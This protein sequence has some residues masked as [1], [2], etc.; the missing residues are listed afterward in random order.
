MLSSAAELKLFYH[1]SEKM[2][3][4]EFQTF[5]ALIDYVVAL[6]LTFKPEA[7]I[8]RSFL[9]FKDLR[10]GF[11]KEL[12]RSE[13]GKLWKELI[14][15]HPDFPSAGDLKRNMSISNIYI[16]M[17]DIHG[18]TRFC[19][20]SKG[21]L[22]R[23]RKLDD[24][25]HEGIRK[26][27]RGNHALANR[28]R[29]DEIVVVASSATDC[30]KTT[31]EIISTFSKHAVVKDRAVGTTR[32]DYSI[33]LPD[34]KVTAGI[35]G[36]NLTTPLIITESGLL[37]GFL[38]NTAARLQTL[39]NELSPKDSKIITT[40]SVYSS[41]VKE[42]KVVKSDLFASKLLKFFNM[43][44]VSFKGTK[45]NCYEIIFNPREQYR[46]NYNP[47]LTTLQES[48]RQ[49]LWKGRVFPDLLD[50]VLQ[51]C[52]AM[53]AFAVDLVRGGDRQKVT[54]D[55][56]TRLAE[57]ARNHYNGENYPA[58][59]ADL[60]RLAEHVDSVPEFDRLIVRYVTEV[61]R[62]FELL[63]AELAQRLE[64]EILS[65]IDVIFEPRYKTVYEKAQEYIDT[66][67]KLKAFA[68]KS[69]ALGNK[70]STWYSLVED[71]K[72]DLKLELY[73]G[74]R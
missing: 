10:W 67:E 11:L 27:A 22:S 16:A 21:N 33:I 8:E 43:G 73:S 66:Y 57:Q 30:I 63:A 29:G 36:G 39:A 12:S 60:S 53:P 51:V 3:A 20:E 37:S 14:L 7:V 34:F 38:L 45:V 61:S 17:L 19:Q 64:R 44:P 48:L 32:S 2:M 6:K 35:A 72:E 52:G 31:F 62:R 55:S 15:L 58:A 49:K 23:L 18:Y 69:N 65:K 25:L 59:V 26:I 28:E 1:L 71:K 68:M 5:S 46:L 40:N 50:L 42:N 13:Y 74:K 47:A 54:N 24:F 56:I 9:L 4:G 41:F 70:K